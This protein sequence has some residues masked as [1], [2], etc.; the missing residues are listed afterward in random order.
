MAKANLDSLAKALNTLSEH[1]EKQREHL[2][3]IAGGM[4]PI[5]LAG[6]LITKGIEMLIGSVVGGMKTIADMRIQNADLL[7][8]QKKMREQI[9]KQGINIGTLTQ[10][11]QMQ[12]N[13]HRIGYKEINAELREQLV[14]LDKTDKQGQDV[15][16]FMSTLIEK[17]ADLRTQTL[18]AQKITDVSR[19][20]GQSARAAISAAEQMG[21][22]ITVLKAIGLDDDVLEAVLI[23]AEEMPG[24][25]AA[26][27]GK[28]AEAM[29]NPKD[30]TKS[31]LLGMYQGG[32]DFLMENASVQDRVAV[33]MRTAEEAGSL[34][35]RFL[36]QAGGDPWLL[37][38]YRE[39]FLGEGG[40]LAI[41]V[42]NAFKMKGSA[43]DIGTGADSFK[44]STDEYAGSFLRVAETLQLAGEI[45]AT[46][47]EDQLLGPKGL[48]SEVFRIANDIGDMIPSWNTI[49][50]AFIWIASHLGGAPLTSQ[51]SSVA[52]EFGLFTRAGMDMIGGD[53]LELGTK[54]ARQMQAA[55]AQSIMAQT[56]EGMSNKEY[57]RLRKRQE[58]I[59][60]VERY[61]RGSGSE[62][63]TGNMEEMRRDIGSMIGG[64]WAMGM[65]EEG[66]MSMNPISQ[67][68]KVG[69]MEYAA[70]LDLIINTMRGEMKDTDAR[71]TEMISRQFD[72]GG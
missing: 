66:G 52:Q 20:T 69:L 41:Q 51:E 22:Q 8:D 17:G 7:V 38:K 18:I 71:V 57:A 64:A 13:L 70:K 53:A 23:A 5:S 30:I 43:K 59:Y 65:N 2:S 49:A 50:D 72:S 21:D 54:G 12:L 9:V 45:V 27:L 48:I 24:Q 28:F 6:G 14:W 39:T 4:K 55:F 68:V 1:S 16:K 36:K 56:P 32:K 58:D 60:N 67:G 10:H 3:E 11:S 46:T 29:V 62:A 63:W 35:E 40:I 42:K 15:L 25:N 47:F 44:D 37:Q 33:L 31:M 61:G 34:S 26:S 19:Y